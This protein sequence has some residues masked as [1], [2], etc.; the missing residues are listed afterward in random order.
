FVLQM[1][2][3]VIYFVLI[4]TLFSI[5]LALMAAPLVQS[6]TDFPLIDIGVARHY[7]PL[8]STPLFLL[9]G[10]LIWTLTMHLGRLIGQVHGRYAKR[11]LVTE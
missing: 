9:A 10:F 1:P 2:L 8:W 7:L 4:V 6:I 5:S 11:F 3:G